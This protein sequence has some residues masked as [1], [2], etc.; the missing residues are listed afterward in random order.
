[1]SGRQPLR[2]T[3]RERISRRVAAALNGETYS[4]VEM[5]HDLERL[6]THPIWEQQDQAAQT[7]EMLADALEEVQDDLG[8]G[9]INWEPNYP[10][11]QHALQVAQAALAAAEVTS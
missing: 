5:A 9:R 8:G 1:M 6:A 7:I 10:E 11:V 2:R 4:V 3:E